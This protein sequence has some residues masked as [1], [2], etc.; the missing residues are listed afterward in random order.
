MSPI[1]LSDPSYQTKSTHMNPRRWAVH[2]FSVYSPN[3]HQRRIGDC[4]WLL[5]FVS[6]LCAHSILAEYKQDVGMGQTQRTQ[7]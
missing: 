2:H 4:L 6:S 1:S 7:R 3:T 5:T